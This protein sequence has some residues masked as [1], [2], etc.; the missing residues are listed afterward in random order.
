MAGGRRWLSALL[1]SVLVA[2]T[3]CSGGNGGVATPTESS[4]PPDASQQQVEDDKPKDPI[5]LLIH[6]GGVSEEEFRERFGPVLEEQ[7]PHITV[8]YMQ[9]GT[10][11]SVKDLVTQGTIPDIVRTD[12]PT[13]IS[14]YLDLD[15]GEDLR[16][17]VEKHS[18]DLARFNEVFVEEIVDLAGSDELYGLPV[19]PFFPQVLYYNKDLFDKFGVDYPTDGMTWDQVYELA[20]TMT[21]SE[22]GVQYRGFSFNPSA[23]LRDNPFSQPILDPSQ[24][25]LA[26]AEQWRVIF[27]NFLRFYQLPGNNIAE[28]NSAES[29]EFGKGHVAM[30]LNQHSVYLKIPEEINWDIVSYPLM[31]GAPEL[32]AQRGPA[33]FSLTKQ[34][35]HKEEAFEVIMAMLSEEVQMQDSLKGIPTTLVNEEIKSALGTEHPTYSQKNMDAINFYEPVPYTPKRAESLA[36][37]PGAVQQKLLQET[38]FELANGT[39]DINTALRQLDEKLKQEVENVKQG[40]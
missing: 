17:Y 12:V 4:P 27:Q 25:Q 37:V 39:I 2:L 33:Y 23:S 31:E 34:G 20:K 16:P 22:D 19:P 18:Y 6:G 9:N 26:D 40:L 5:T 13:L 38:F 35:Q 14:N 32:M 24:D 3:A 21:R 11:T 8:D 29:N 36:E 30:Q 15:L 7:F 1:G 10:G 28:N